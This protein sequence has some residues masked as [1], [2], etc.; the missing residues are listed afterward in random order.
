MMMMVWWDNSGR[1]G[2][3]TGAVWYEMCWIS[4]SYIAVLA[5]EQHKGP[6]M[7]TQKQ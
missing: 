5:L 1:G 6:L 2:M 7:A 4:I 3:V